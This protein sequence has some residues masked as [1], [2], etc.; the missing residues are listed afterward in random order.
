MQSISSEE[1]IYIY[2]LKIFSAI[3]LNNSAMLLLP[4]PYSQFR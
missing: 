2:S 3:L 1:F 4:T